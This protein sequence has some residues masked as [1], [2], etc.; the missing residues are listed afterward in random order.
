MRKQSNGKVQRSAAEW[1]ALIERYEQSGLGMVA[2][3]TRAGVALN[4][5]KKRYYA[6]RRAG[7]AAAAFVEL[8][9]PSI[10]TVPDWELELTLPNGVRVSA[11]G[12]GRVE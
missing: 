11:R 3:C 1:R 12:A 10:S 9:P 5:F 6:Y 8:P 2:F 7:R 4:S